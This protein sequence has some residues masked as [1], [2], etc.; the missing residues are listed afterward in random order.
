MDKW[1][2]KSNSGF[3]NKPKY[4][5]NRWIYICRSWFDVAAVGKIS[6]GT[7]PFFCF[8]VQIPILQ[9]TTKRIQLQTIIKWVEGEGRVGGWWWGRSGGQI[10]GAKR[11]NGQS[12]LRDGLEEDAVEMVAGGPYS[13]G[14]RLNSRDRAPPGNDDD[15]GR[16]ECCAAASWDSEPNSHNW[17]SE[18][19]SSVSVGRKKY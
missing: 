12:I 7:R 1:E 5:P 4:I 17:P 6:V 9:R 13:K 2:G 3:W 19:S 14:N 18:T 15:A 16:D 8:V 11:G 10:C